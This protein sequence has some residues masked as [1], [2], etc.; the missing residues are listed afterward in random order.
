[1]DHLTSL[2]WLIIDADVCF[3]QSDKREPEAFRKMFIG[4]LDYRTTDE[5]LKEFFE[6]WGDIVDVV[7]MKDPMTKRWAAFIKYTMIL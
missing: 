7:V 5:S 2:L 6:K 4:G 1:M 3:F